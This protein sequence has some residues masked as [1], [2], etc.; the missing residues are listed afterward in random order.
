MA[1]DEGPDRVDILIAEDDAPTRRGLR[2]LLEHWGFRCAEAGDGVEAIDLAVRQPPR[3]VLL[4]LVMPRLDGLAVARALR[5]DPRTRPTH[6]HCLTGLTDPQARRWALEAG[7]EG[8]FVK[9]VDPADLLDA[10]RGP[11]ASAATTR[12]SGLTLGE[13][14]SLLDWLQHQGCTGLRVA[15]EEEGAAVYCICPPGW[16]VYR[17]ESGAVRF[18]KSEEGQ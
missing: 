10:L 7:C 17:D 16:H 6:I 5:A 3:C 14:E 1:T 9:P 15:L 18:R 2:R 11:A 4:D 12:L 8:F 13:A